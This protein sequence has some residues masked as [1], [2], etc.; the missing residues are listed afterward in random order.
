LRF[1]KFKIHTAP[2]KY[3]YNFRDG[4]RLTVIL[5]CENTPQGLITDLKAQ[6]LEEVFVRL[7]S[8][9]MAYE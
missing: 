2:L 7:T 6:N 5:L 3:N 4:I 9:D 1:F 8:Q